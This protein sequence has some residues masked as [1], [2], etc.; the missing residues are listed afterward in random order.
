MDR[1]LLDTQRVYDGYDTIEPE[2]DK[3]ICQDSRET[4]EKTEAERKEKITDFKNL[5]EILWTTVDHFIP[6]LNNWFKGLTDKRD[7]DSIIYNR[8]TILWTMLLTLITKQ[9]SRKQIT[10]EMRKEDKFCNNLKELSGQ[11]DL[12]MVPHGDSVEYLSMRMKPEEMEALNVKVI[13]ALIRGRALERYRLLDKYYTIAI[14]G[15]HIHTFYY[16]HCDNCSVREDKNGKKIWI[17]SKL[18]ASLVTAAGLCLPMASEWIEKEENC[19]KEDCE[20]KAFYRLI[21]K[22]RKYYPQLPMCILLDALFAG[23]PEFKALSDMRMEWI[24]V[25][26]EGTM[27][28]AYK[29]VMKIKGTFSKDNVIVRKEEKEIPLRLHRTHH[30]RLIRTKAAYQKRIVKKE[31][32]YTWAHEEH[33][34]E[35]RKFN[36]MTC[37]DVE[38]GLVKCDY[39]WLVSDGL[40]LNKNNV[41]ELAEKGGRCRWKIENE[42][43]NIQKNGGYELKHLYSRDEISMKIWIYMLDIAH[44][45]NQLIERGSLIQKKIFGSIKNIAKKMFRHFCYYDLEKGTERARIQIRLCWDTS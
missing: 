24:V 18:Q 17:H 29:W 43:I 44:I 39:V 40:N 6:E 3:D 15:V 23:E 9:K 25:F 7:Q 26:K 20:I 5:V 32:T 30:E 41:V 12:E 36:I 2:N 27:P 4:Q 34:D 28:E 19:D 8:E 35:Q 21:K 14:D 42:G 10:D 31:T 33:W 1:K 22:I 45:I 37:K 16:K 11:K 38:D 13:R